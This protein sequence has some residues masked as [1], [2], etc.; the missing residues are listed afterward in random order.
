MWYLRSIVAHSHSNKG[1]EKTNQKNEREKA[2]IKDF[3]T[4]NEKIEINVNKVQRFNLS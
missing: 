4:M 3:K 2:S 1:N